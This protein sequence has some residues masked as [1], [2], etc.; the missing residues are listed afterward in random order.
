MTDPNYP[1]WE[2]HSHGLLGISRDELRALRQTHL[3][4]GTHWAN[5]K[6]RVCLSEIGLQ[7]IR[8][9]LKLNQSP[10]TQ[11]SATA[12]EPNP[13]TPSASSSIAAPPVNQSPAR[14]TPE[15]RPHRLLPEKTADATPQPHEKTLRVWRT[16]R[17]NRIIE[18]IDPAHEGL[19][20]P[21]ILR[22]KVRA[23]QHFT[24][25]LTNGQWMEFPARHIQADLYEI[26]RPGPK[27]RGRW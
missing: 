27:A 25:R 26:A 15:L 14:I 12:A 24:R 20:P 23:S 1:H 9:T 8:D 6:N 3:T 5:I 22:V 13:A 11:P 10:V 18:A 2:S 19:R 16:V 7:K 17:N 21:P 4:E